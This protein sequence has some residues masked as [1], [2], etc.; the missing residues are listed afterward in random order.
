LIGRSEDTVCVGPQPEHRV[1][2]LNRP[3]SEFLI[4]ALA[5]A[6][7][8]LAALSTRAQMTLS[9]EKLFPPDCHRSRR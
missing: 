3:E 8:C 9:L 4:A 2:E 5:E 1:E 6:E 7:Q